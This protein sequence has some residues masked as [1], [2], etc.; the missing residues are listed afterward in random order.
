MLRYRVF[1]ALSI[2]LAH[3]PRSVAY[4]FATLAGHLGF[5]LNAP[6]RRVCEDNVR[7][8][9]SPSA[10]PA[11]VR[12][13][14]RGCFL[15]ASRYYVDLARIPL[16]EPS[17]FIRDNITVHGFEHLETA[18]AT[19]KGLIVAGIHY[20][21]PE[22]VAQAMSGRGYHFLALVE[23]LEPRPL[24]DLIQRLRSS[25]G[26]LFVEVGWSGI[27]AALKHLKSGGVVCILCDRDIQDGGE[28]VPFFG[29]PARIPSGAVDL[30]RHTGATIV[31]AI[32]RRIGDDRFSLHVEPAFEL[33]KTGR[34]EEDRRTNTARL[35][36]VFEKYLR[37]DPSQ[38][39][40]L[41]KRIWPGDIP[42]PPP[43]SFKGRRR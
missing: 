11:E 9:I 39:F 23:P 8:A 12:A 35:I 30:A 21:N 29:E 18:K 4:A 33:V 3:V 42:L 32:T 22:Y 16:M 1:L 2:F 24:A 14:V 34:V 43:P 17:R 41:E 15:A 25:Q 19:G 38:W 40:V 31:P 37:K 6:A 36:Q 20:G 26:Q 5:L 7:H 28:L 27:K 13:A 10:S